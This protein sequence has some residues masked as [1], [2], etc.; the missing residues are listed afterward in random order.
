M[1][2]DKKV[3][4]LKCWLRA[5]IAYAALSF[6]WLT[7]LWVGMTADSAV[8]SAGQVNA[9]IS[10]NSAFAE[11]LVISDIYIALFSVVY[12]FSSIFFQIKNM[13]SSAKRALHVFVNYCAAMVCFYGLHSSAK[14]VAPKMWI[15]LLFLATIAYFI[16]YGIGALIMH[17]VN[18]RK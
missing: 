13:P 14:E 18:K 10:N 1:M 12:G 5:F 9:V 6:G 3:I 8:T 17:F 16:V 2:N 7:F 11:R 4:F 15:T